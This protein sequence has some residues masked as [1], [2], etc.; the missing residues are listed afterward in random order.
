MEDDLKN[1]R[2]SQNWK[3]TSKMEDDL[4]NG[5]RPQKWKTTSKNRRW[6]LSVVQKDP[7]QYPHFQK[8]T[9]LNLLTFQKW[10]PSISS[11]SK[12]YPP[13]SPHFPKMTPLNLLTL[14]KCPP[15]ISSLSKN[16]PPQSPHFPKLTTLNFLTF[17]KLPPTMRRQNY[18]S[19]ISTILQRRDAGVS[20]FEHILLVSNSV[21]C[22]HQSL[23]TEMLCV[24]SIRWKWYS[25]VD[26]LNFVHCTTWRIF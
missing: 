1:G 23:L 14:Q 12:H 13:Q 26:F 18:I 15:S 5:R 8:M 21:P 19:V 20:F 11:L 17:Q 6:P 16:D 10:H 25:F 4:K 9:L 24:F 22:W 3:M 7:P 2:W